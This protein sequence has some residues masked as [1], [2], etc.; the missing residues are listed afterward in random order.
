MRVERAFRVVQGDNPFLE[1]MSRRI[2]SVID[3]A[4]SWT[5]Y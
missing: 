5:K 1:S 4:D 3:A 2:E